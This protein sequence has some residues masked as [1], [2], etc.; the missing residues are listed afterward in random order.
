MFRLFWG[1]F[2]FF[3]K[4]FFGYFM[5]F[6]KCLNLLGNVGDFFGECSLVNCEMADFLLL[7]ITL[8]IVECS[9]SCLYKLIIQLF[10]HF[11]YPHVL[12]QIHQKITPVMFSHAPRLHSTS[13]YTRKSLQ[14]C[15]LP[16][17]LFFFFK[18]DIILWT[19]LSS[20]FLR[21]EDFLNKKENS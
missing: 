12:T 10:L 11:Q 15:S 16:I 17:T 5:A 7:T 20:C 18:H 21:V 1:M 6:V 8:I 3:V 2:Y 19:T 13:S 14:L 4:C 9:N